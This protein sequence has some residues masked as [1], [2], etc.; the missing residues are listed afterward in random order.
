MKL[1]QVS[2]LRCDLAV[3]TER[4]SDVQFVSLRAISDVAKLDVS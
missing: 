3:C 1:L 2:E 4:L